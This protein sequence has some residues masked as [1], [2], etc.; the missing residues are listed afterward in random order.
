MSAK[1]NGANHYLWFD[2]EYTTL[3]MERAQLLQV[4]L[5]VTDAKRRRILP[6]EQDVNLYLAFEGKADPWVEENMG[7]V[8]AK[9]KANGIP[10]G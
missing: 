3:D 5:C 8:L 1:K 7:T 2:T 9:C 6:P 10:T 4:S